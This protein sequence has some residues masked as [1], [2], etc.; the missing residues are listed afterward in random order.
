MSILAMGKKLNMSQLFL[1][2]GT[3]IPITWL[4]MQTSVTSVQEGAIVVITGESKGK[5]FTGVVKK[6]G[7]KGGPA[8][9]GQSDRHR[10]PGSIGSTTAAQVIK[11]KKMAGRHGGKTITIKKVR[12]MK[13]DDNKV[14]VLGPVPGS[15]GSTVKIKLED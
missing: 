5:G 8:T 14:A 4:S 15:Y 6:Y 9:H 13:V 2:D 3:L 7:F 12:V 1:E 10:A 11:G